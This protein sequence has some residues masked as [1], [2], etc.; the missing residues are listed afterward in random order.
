MADAPDSATRSKRVLIS[1]AHESAEHRAR[2]RKLADQLRAH[3]IDAMIDQYEPHPAEGWP[4][5]MERQIENSDFVLLVFTE[6]YQ[7]RAVGKEEPGRGLGV[8]WEADLIREEL[9]DSPHHN[10]RFIPVVFDASHQQFITKKLKAVTRYV[11][12]EQ[13][14]NAT[15]EDNQY[16]MLYRHMTGQPLVAKPELGRLIKLDAINA[17]N[18][19]PSVQTSVAIADATPDTVA[20]SQ[21]S[22]VRSKGIVLMAETCP[23]SKPTAD[24]ITRFLREQGY[25][26]L[27][28][29]PYSIARDVRP[30]LTQAIQQSLLVVQVLGI[31]PFAKSK[32]LKPQRVEQ[33][34]VSTTKELKGEKALLSWVDEAL[35]LTLVADDDYADFLKTAISESAEEFKKTTLL[36]RLAQLTAQSRSVGRTLFVHHHSDDVESA[37]EV[38][39]KAATVAEDKLA[40]ELEVFRIDENRDVSA[41]IGTDPVH[42][43]VVVYGQCDEEWVEQH[44]KALK[45]ICNAAN[46]K[47]KLKRPPGAIV[48]AVANRPPLRRVPDDW[49]EFQSSEDPKL[50]RFVETVCGKEVR[51]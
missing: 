36:D 31:T 32:S 28:P 29:D 11:L 18:A 47:H 26:V 12:D 20:P 13:D 33:W 39:R 23:E 19:K 35:D 43:L 30:E 9:Y 51:S 4:Q 25:E 7:R 15:S 34:I 21:P 37:K 38:A 45:K 8:A 17:P 3:G 40:E 42:G 10:E 16:A 49:D 22:T 48:K 50:T 2:I 14:L 41:A 46:L 24:N 27:V 1:Y 6:T 5:W 44:A